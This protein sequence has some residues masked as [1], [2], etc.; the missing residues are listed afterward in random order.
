M[1]DKGLPSAGRL[2]APAAPVAS[3]C[4]LGSVPAPGGLASP[5]ALLLLAGSLM[6]LPAIT[7]QHTSGTGV[8]KVPVTPKGHSEVFLLSFI[9]PKQFRG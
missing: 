7:S 9:K 2:V 5:A 6:E 8:I 4:V 3:L 1:L